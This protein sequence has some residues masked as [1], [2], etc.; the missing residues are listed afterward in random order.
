MK[1][2]LRSLREDLLSEDSYVS[3]MSKIL[4]LKYELLDEDKI[5]KEEFKNKN[6]YGKVNESGE[7]EDN[8]LIIS[9]DLENRSY[10]IHKQS[11]DSTVKFESLSELTSAISIVE[12]IEYGK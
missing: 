6:V 10:E 2:S 5:I 4:E 1:K 9:T 12:G 3:P 8:L 11:S 7:I